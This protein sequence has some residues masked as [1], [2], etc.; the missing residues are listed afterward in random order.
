M[1]NEVIKVLDA[2]SQKFGLVI[3][4]TSAN[5]L[6]YL[7]QLYGKY[8]TYEIATS[9]VWM[10]IGIGLLP[11]GKYVIEKAE[12]YWGKYEEDWRSDYDIAT[13][14]FGILAGSIIIVGIVVVLDQTFDIIT[15]ITFPEK[16]IIEEL[17][18]VYSSLK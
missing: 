9:V 4:W 15:C 1:S 3:D 6:L 5:A 10:L 7:Q 2:F 12:Y 11:V 16:V 14:W 18:S 13:T 8:I 17:Q